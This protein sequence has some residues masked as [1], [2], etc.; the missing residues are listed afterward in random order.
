MMNELPP[1][2]GL[3]KQLR[4][5]FHEHF[6]QQE[7]P[8]ELRATLLRKAERVSGKKRKHQH[9]IFIAQPTKKNASG[10]A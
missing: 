6:D 10:P 5:I 9:P 3:D 7:P 4:V 1:D 2:D 8:G